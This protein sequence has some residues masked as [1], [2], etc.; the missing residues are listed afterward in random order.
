M[1]ILLC[2]SLL[3]T[4]L[5]ACNTIEGAGRDIRSAGETISGSAQK[6]KEEMR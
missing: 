5:S 4:A 6:T 2:F 3:I 1:R